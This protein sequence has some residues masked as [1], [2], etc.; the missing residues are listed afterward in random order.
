MLIKNCQLGS[1]CKAVYVFL[2]IL[3]CTQFHP[4]FPCVVAW[5]N[6]KLQNKS[7]E[8]R[9]WL[10]QVVLQASHCCFAAEGIKPSLLV[11]ENTLVWI[12]FCFS[13]YRFEISIMGET[14][15]LRGFY[16]YLYSLSLPERRMSTQ[17]CSQSSAKASMRLMKTRAVWTGLL[18]Q[19]R[20]IIPPWSLQMWVSYFS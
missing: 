9:H 6:N 14:H 15:F 16:F 13:A 17:S 20:R 4:L 11:G 8:T 2:Y 18:F 7:I 5:S 1:Y 10:L 3:A 12:I 19:Y